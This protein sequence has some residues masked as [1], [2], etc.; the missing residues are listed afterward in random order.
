MKKGDDAKSTKDVKEGDG[1]TLSYLI[2]HMKIL[3]LDSS[4]DGDESNQ[5]TTQRFYKLGM[6]T[7]WHYIKYFNL[8]IV[9]F[10]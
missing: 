10:P 1:F 7:H 2:I 6:T 4:W 9:C 5:S 8:N 3:L